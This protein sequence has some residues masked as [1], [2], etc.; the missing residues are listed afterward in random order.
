MMRAN[1]PKIVI[2]ESLPVTAPPAH[3]GFSKGSL[4]LYGMVIIITERSVCD[5]NH[6]QTRNTSCD[7]GA[8]GKPCAIDLR[9][10]S[11]SP[12]GTN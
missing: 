4:G 5:E 2:D 10:A 1:E 8:E 9:I 3:S 7:D 12:C 6:S 11:S